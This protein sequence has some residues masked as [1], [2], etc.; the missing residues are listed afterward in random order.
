MH[1]LT[2]AARWAKQ[3]ERT[4]KAIPAGFAR[5][6]IRMV[7]YV[8]LA[9]VPAFVMLLLTTMERRGHE[10]AQAQADALSLVRLASAQQERLIEGARELLAGLAQLPAVRRG[11]TIACDDLLFDLWEKSPRYTNLGAVRPDGKI[12]CSATPVRGPIN[13]GDRAFSGAPSRSVRSPSATTRSTH[14]AVARF[15]HLH[16]PCWIEPVGL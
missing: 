7:L 4:V 15:S 12:F 8:I 1:S 3:I 13:V 10:A 9:L 5:L 16:T 11:D 14:P 2:S 6:Q